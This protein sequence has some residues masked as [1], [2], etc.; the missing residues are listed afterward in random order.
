LHYFNEFY[1][2]EGELIKDIN[3]FI[4]DF[5]SSNTRVLGFSV[6]MISIYFANVVAKLIK[7][8]DQELYILIKEQDQELYIRT[9]D[10]S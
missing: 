3:K 9:G 4:N 2:T 7:E 5:L 10:P 1:I 6:N 8:Q